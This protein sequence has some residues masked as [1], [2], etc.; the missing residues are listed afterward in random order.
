ME[1]KRRKEAER[2]RSRR[3]EI[4]TEPNLKQ[5]RKGEEVQRN[6]AEKAEEG[7]GGV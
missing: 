1:S 3:K 6:Q 4:N 5:R 7:G 2:A